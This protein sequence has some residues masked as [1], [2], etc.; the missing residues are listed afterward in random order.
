[1][2]PFVRLSDINR[3]K[4]SSHKKKQQDVCISKKHCML[5]SEMYRIGRIASGTN[6]L[7]SLTQLKT[8]NILLIVSTL[9][10]QL[11]NSLL[12]F[13]WLILRNCVQ[14]SHKSNSK[15][16][17]NCTLQ[18]WI[19]HKYNLWSDFRSIHY[20]IIQKQKFRHHALKMNSPK[21]LSFSQAA[22]LFKCGIFQIR[23][24]IYYTFTKNTFNPLHCI[25]KKTPH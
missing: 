9:A 10:N 20:L 4:T 7:G 13:I 14:N 2:K 5:S 16:F 17:Q 12:S 11:F 6:D 24:L 15:C 23:K 18:D 22:F 1:M 25:A 3:G 19:F 8:R 21:Q